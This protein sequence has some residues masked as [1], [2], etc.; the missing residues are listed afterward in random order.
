MNSA[1]TVLDPLSLRSLIRVTSAVKSTQE[2]NCARFRAIEMENTQRLA[3]WRRTGPARRAQERGAATQAGTAKRDQWTNKYDAS[4]A[5]ANSRSAPHQPLCRGPT[6]TS[7]RA[8]PGVTN[9][10][11]TVARSVNY[12]AGSKVHIAGLRSEQWS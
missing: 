8:D 10:A 7:G 2:R 1:W 9:G 5:K 11:S 6:L 12:L 3:R 4:S